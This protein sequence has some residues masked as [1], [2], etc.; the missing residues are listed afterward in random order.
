M[1]LFA[2]LEREERKQITWRPENPPP[3][4]GIT[5]V[6]VD[7]ETSGLAWWRGDHIIGI[8]IAFRE[9][10]GK[11]VTYYLP[12]GHAGGGN[13]DEAVV[14]EWC[15]RELRNKIL[16][17]HNA[18]FDN[19]M[20]YSW[21]VDLE[22]QGCVWRDTLHM[23]ALDDD[24]RAVQWP[25]HPRRGFSLDQ[26]AEDY[27][28]ATAQKLKKT[29]IT[30]QLINF[31]RMKDYHAGEIALY[32]EQDVRL[33]GRLHDALMIRMEDQDLRRVLDLESRCIYPTCE[34]ERNPSPLDMEL[35][36]KWEKETEE[37]LHSY[38]K[39]IKNET[40]ITFSDTAKTWR[41]LFDKLKLDYPMITTKDKHG[42]PVTRVGFTSNAMEAYLDH[43]TLVLATKVKGIKSIRS[44]FIVKYIMGSE[45]GYLRTAFHQLRGDEGGTI[46]G[47]YSSSGYKID[48]ENIGANLQQVFTGTHR[49][50]KFSNIIGD[51]YPIKKLFLPEP[52]KKWYAVDAAQ[53]EYRILTH[54]TEAKEILAAYEKNPSVSYHKLV[55]K[56]V[57]EVQPD[58][59][60]DNL[61][62]VNF[63]IIY[64]ASPPKVA[65]MLRLPVP[66]VESLYRMYQTRFPEP[67]ML[68]A[69]AKRIAKN[70][71]YVKSIL[72][73]RARFPSDAVRHKRVKFH[74]ALNSIIQPSAADVMKL[75][76]CEVYE[77]RK[78]LG[79]K[80]RLTVHDE[81]CGD[82]ESEEQ[83][84]MIDQ[85]LNQQALPF[86]V[87]I[88]WEGSTGDNWYS[89]KSDAKP[90]QQL[91]EEQKARVEAMWAKRRVV[92]NK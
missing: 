78:E 70:R 72:G 24:L 56:M 41:A 10:E 17:G 9:R 46:T 65:E 92:V 34:L 49:N 1:D 26:C 35:L 79:I 19:H 54:Y 59:V 38:Q 22:A 36:V 16:I 31:S 28:G 42:N 80:L 23:V 4:D 8:A 15:R 12:F 43:P 62:T 7:T 66:E 55:M 89:A 13:L 85:V 77:M 20:F 68:M 48:G 58:I 82:V 45:D 71:G 39:Q 37:K 81:L 75:K 69:K 47:R 44:K 30:N 51:N 6:V 25:G 27:V 40:G 14:K 11:W 76:L 52:G 74:K 63:S 53:I 2:D 84:Q 86:K 3:L 73:R 50:Y 64:G 21:G 33:T 18:K 67:S 5:E 57:Q 32:G 88:L 83:A 29:N 61:K 90:E 91:T 87:P 60:Y